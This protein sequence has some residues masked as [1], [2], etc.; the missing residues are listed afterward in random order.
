MPLG[1]RP[2]P[3]GLCVKWGPSFLA[4]KGAEPPIFGQCLLR[5]NGCMDQDATWHG[6]GLGPRHIVLDGDP[7][8]FPKK[9]AQPP[10]IFGT[11]LLWPN[12]C[13]HQAATWC[14]GRCRPQ[15]TRLC[16]R[17]GP[18]SPSQ[19]GRSPKFSADVYY[20]Q[21]AAW[22]MMPFGAEVGVRLRDIVL[23]GDPAPVH[24]GAQPPIFGHCQL[25]P[26]GWMD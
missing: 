21:T 14:G 8:P 2:H 11:F 25:L 16:A 1:G 19:K 15:P 7:T 22:V 24:K 23:H 10:P 26:N 9:G 18:S 6:V 20:G 12:G 3:R 17:W 4:K 13:M 5:P